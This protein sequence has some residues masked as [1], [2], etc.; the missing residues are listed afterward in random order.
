MAFVRYKDV[1]GRRYYQLVRNY[2]ENGRHRQ[3]VLY[4]LG[5]YS[6]LDEA[7][8]AERRMEIRLQDELARS[9]RQAARL[10]EK[11]LHNRRERFGN[12]IPSI[13]EARNIR[14]KAL[15][16]YKEGKSSEDLRIARLEEQLAENI[17]EYYVQQRFVSM[18]SD[19]IESI[20]KKIDELLDLKQKYQV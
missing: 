9:Y 16:L 1:G 13:E 12:E 6:T 4:H 18:E 20:Q 14:K 2:R 10:R 11:I 15:E 8:G 5:K 19:I 3:E 7:I 17:R